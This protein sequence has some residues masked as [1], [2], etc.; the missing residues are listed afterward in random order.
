V[1]TRWIVPAEETRFGV[2]ELL[3]G[4]VSLSTDSTAFIVDFDPV[5]FSQTLGDLCPAC[6]LADGLTVPKPPFTASL[7]SQISFPP[8][9]SAIT[10][11]DGQVLIEIQNGFGFDPI[12]PGGPATGGLTLTITD[13][14]DGDVL[15]TLDIDGATTSFAAGTTLV[16]T[17]DLNH[18]VVDGTLVT[19]I[20][21]NSPLGNS[22]TID[23]SDQLAVTATPVTVQVMDVTINVSNRTVDFDPV[24]L[25]LSDV[26]QDIENR[27]VAGSFTLDV[28]NPFGLSAGFQ[29]TIDA[30][31]ISA[32]QKSAVV[33]TAPQSS[34]NIAFTTDE[35]RSILGTPDVV[36]SG[37][38]VVDPTVGDITVLPGQELILSANLDLTLRIGGGN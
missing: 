30:P 14:A 34:V 28:T 22:V 8:E 23:A 32:I 6:A 24:S 27:V 5:S 20:L 21:V 19:E 3:P 1:E 15:A 17:L 16:R 2:E 13:D 4:D 33:T 37:G 35:L 25:D 9:V 18:T 36:L 11:L 7:V 29:I 10:V 12:Q 38:A 26:D 31:S